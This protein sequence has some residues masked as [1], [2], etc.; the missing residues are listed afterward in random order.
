MHM[1]FCLIGCGDIAYTMHAPAY[2]AYQKKRPEFQLAA[3]C[4]AQE[5]RAKAMQE[6]FGFARYYTNY[7][8]MLRIEKPDAVAVAVSETAAVNV[9]VD[10]LRAGLPLLIEKPPGRQSCDTER[11]IQAAMETNTPCQVAFNRRYMPVFTTMRAIAPE[12]IQLITYDMVRCNRS[13]QKFSNTA[14]HA[15]DAVRYLANA[16]YRHVRFHYDEMPE[17]GPGV[18]NILMLCEMTSGAQAQIRICPMSGVTLE[19]AAIHAENRLIAGYTPVWGAYDTPGRIE[20]FKNN[21]APEIISFEHCP[22]FQSNG[23]LAENEAFFDAII[24]GRRPLPSVE[25]SMNTMLVKECL[26][27]RAQEFHADA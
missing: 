18:C 26:D 22:Q 27:R 8:D 13:D 11:L 14:V 12:K 24:E 19:R 2:K 15:I 6:S 10:V 1:K 16:D 20:D 7:H 17:Y 9:G 23:F 3:C 25:T 21:Q 4:D 5:D